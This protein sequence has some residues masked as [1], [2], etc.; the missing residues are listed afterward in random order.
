MLEAFQAVFAA[1]RVAALRYEHILKIPTGP[2]EILK[3]TTRGNPIETLRFVGRFRR[4][5][6]AKN[7]RRT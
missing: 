3:R 6:P 1:L 2:R 4:K 5:R 7:E